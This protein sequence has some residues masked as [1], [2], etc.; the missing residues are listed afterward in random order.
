MRKLN[1]EYVKKYEAKYEKE[2][3]IREKIEEINEKIEECGKIEK[4]YADEENKVLDKRTMI[5]RALA[6]VEDAKI[7]GDAGSDGSLC[8]AEQEK[9][10]TKTNGCS[11]AVDIFDGYKKSAEEYSKGKKMMDEMKKSMESVVKE[12]EKL[13]DERL[14][15]FMD[16][17]KKINQYLGEIFKNLTYGGAAELGMVDYLSPFTGGI[18]LNVMPPKKS[19]K[20]VSSLSGGEKTLSSLA[21]LF[22]LH[23]YKPS[24]L[25]V[26][27]EIDAALDYRNVGT[28]A[29]YLK[30]ISA[31]FLVISLR[32]N[33]FEMANTLVGVYKV[34]EMSHALLLN[35]K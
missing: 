15:I 6:S 17:F 10:M 18:S 28:I 25:Y 4:K 13:R 23:K 19:W 30:S 2:M 5:Q 11:I 12:V 22:A 32:D 9:N 29:N 24:P 7:N 26:M 14:N 20:M 3:G 33:M 35:T 34:D 1:R 16:G 31:Q 27:D 21:L 8:P